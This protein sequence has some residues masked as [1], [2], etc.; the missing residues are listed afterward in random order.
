MTGLT[1]RTARRIVWLAAALL[2]PLPYLALAEGTAPVAGYVFLAGIAGTY[3][4]GVAGTS[5]VSW[6][7]FALLLLH[8]VG[9]GLLLAV[10]ARLVVRRLREPIPA[11]PIGAGIVVAFA[12]ALAVPIYHTPFDDAVAYATWSGLFQ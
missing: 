9:Y 11:W 5:T 6:I 10:G 1:R 12:L 2:L 3:A 4:L 8:A 7:V